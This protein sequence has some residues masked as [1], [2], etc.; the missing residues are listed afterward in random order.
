LSR[1]RIPLF[2][3]FATVK[4]RLRLIVLAG[5]SPAR[6]NKILIGYLYIMRHIILA[7]KATAI[8]ILYIHILHSIAQHWAK[9][10]ILHEN[11]QYIFI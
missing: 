3:V 9:S 7:I 6:G 8:I 5:A 4:N 1:I 11:V 2:P 10:S